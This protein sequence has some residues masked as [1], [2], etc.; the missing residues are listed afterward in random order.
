MARKPRPK[1]AVRVLQTGGIGAGQ[2][3][4]EASVINQL[5]KPPSK[6]ASEHTKKRPKGR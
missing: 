5:M 4:Y 2:I 3:S 1:K 6:A